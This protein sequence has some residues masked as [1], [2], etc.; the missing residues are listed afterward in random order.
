MDE[1]LRLFVWDDFASDYKPGL[2][3]AIAPTIQ[4]AERMVEESVGFWPSNAG[5]CTEYPI[6]AIGFGCTGG[7]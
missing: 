1:K 4:E 6:Q 7:S 2:A 5:K 3:F